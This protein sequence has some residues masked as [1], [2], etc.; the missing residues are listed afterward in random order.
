[1]LVKNF[2]K[3]LNLATK[4]PEFHRK[5]AETQREKEKKRKFSHRLTRTIK[6][7]II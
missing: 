7:K 5:D 6:K 1:M 3:F 2:F 4:K